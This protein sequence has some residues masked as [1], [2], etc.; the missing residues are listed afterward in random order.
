[1]LLNV[2]AR[3]PPIPVIL[4]AF[5]SLIGGSVLTVGGWIYIVHPVTPEDA[6]LAVWPDDTIEE[7]EHYEEEWK[8]VRNDGE[9]WREG[10]DPLAP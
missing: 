1:V 7:A 5:S 2:A 8:N 4:L 9:R 6:E 10:A 3:T